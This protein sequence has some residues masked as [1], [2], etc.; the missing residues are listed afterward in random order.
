MQFVKAEHGQRQHDKHQTEGAQHPGVLQHGLQIGARQ[1][2]H[3]ADAGVGQ[4]HRQHEG[5]RQ[6]KTT[7]G[8]RTA[9]CDQAGE[10][11]HHRQHAGRERHQQAQAEEHDKHPAHMDARQAFGQV[12]VFA[13]RARGHRTLAGRGRIGRDCRRCRDIGQVDTPG[14]RRIA[15][16]RIGAALP[17]DGQRPGIGR[18]DQDPDLVV[19]DLALAVGFIGLGRTGGPQDL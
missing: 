15:K 8:T 18:L 16:T 5:Q 12:L 19:I 14:L 17:A 7:P 10:N 9:A 13:E 11:R 3:R 4:R 2:R 1:R 6:D